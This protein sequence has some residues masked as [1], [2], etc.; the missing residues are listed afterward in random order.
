MTQPTET[1]K[2]RDSREKPSPKELTETL[3]K[4]AEAKFLDL[5]AEDSRA[6]KDCSEAVGGFVARTLDAAKLLSDTLERDARLPEG[7]ARK[8]KPE[9]RASF[10]AYITQAQALAMILPQTLQQARIVQYDPAVQERLRGVTHLI[11]KR[12]QLMDWIEETRAA[13]ALGA[14]KPQASLSELPHILAIMD[15]GW[16]IREELTI[17]ARLQPLL[18]ALEKKAEPAYK[19]QTLRLGAV[20]RGA[21]AVAEEKRRQLGAERATQ[22]LPSAEVIIEAPE[23]SLAVWKR[24]LT[25]GGPTERKRAAQQ[26]LQGVTQFDKDFLRKEAFQQFKQAAEKEVQRLKRINNRDLWGR[27]FNAL[28]WEWA[29]D[30]VITTPEEFDAAAR[31]VL[32]KME[33]QFD[34]IGALPEAK[35]ILGLRATLGA[36]AEGKDVPAGNLVKALDDYGIVQRRAGELISAIQRWQVAQNVEIVGNPAFGRANMLEQITRIDSKTPMGYLRDLSPYGMFRQRSYV[37]E[38]TGRIMLVTDMPAPTELGLQDHAKEIGK[39]AIGVPTAAFLTNMIVKRIPVLG[40]PLARI[41]MPV[42][43]AEASVAGTEALARLERGRQAVK[44]AEATLQLL[45]QN[46]GKMSRDDV[47]RASNTL[48]GNILLLLQTSSPDATPDKADDVSVHE[49]H[50]YTNQLLIALGHPPVHEI[51]PTLRRTKADFGVKQLS[52]ELEQYLT[53]REAEKQPRTEAEQEARTQLNRLRARIEGRTIDDA[54]EL[55]LSNKIPEF[56]HSGIAG[57]RELTAAL[58]AALKSKEFSQEQAKNALS[59]FGKTEAQ[60]RENIFRYAGAMHFHLRRLRAI[61]YAVRQK[62]LPARRGSINHGEFFALPDTKVRFTLGFL[63]ADLERLETQ[64]P[65]PSLLAAARFLET[66]EPTNEELARIWRGEELPTGW[67]S[68]HAVDYLNQR[69]GFPGKR[70]GLGEVLL[71]EWAEVHDYMRLLREEQKTAG[72]SI[73]N[74][75]DIYPLQPPKTLQQNAGGTLFLRLPVGTEW[76]WG[77]ADEKG[78]IRT[79]LGVNDEPA[80]QGKISIAGR[81]RI[82]IWP[83]KEPEKVMWIDIR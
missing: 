65:L 29:R 78:A 20:V 14:D 40:G 2:P 33:K 41:G 58:V 25:E 59:V 32:Q 37:D 83:T 77:M 64:V 8:L 18:D 43:W 49:A 5:A 71:Q 55:I 54:T 10:E 1:P 44:E 69:Y 24:L 30:R 67:G 35:H 68:A 22:G 46:V 17:P 42:V 52:P 75:I 80:H 62:N 4:E 53:S 73:D 15:R 27:F 50:L 34:A 11:V 45:R 60:Q 56:S 6:Y 51:S 61:E 3:R 16:R 47:I 7:D 72:S 23:I 70:K 9:Q 74:P 13:L 38:R 19:D 36:M 66:H 76:S 79:V 57:K 39:L 26:L 82:A 12:D 48:F 28:G 21:N 81:G 63:E 31:D